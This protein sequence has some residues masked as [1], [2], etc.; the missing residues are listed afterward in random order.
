[1]RGR[2]ITTDLEQA[3]YHILFS[4]YKIRNSTATPFEI[5]CFRIM[6]MNT[7]KSRRSSKG[8]SSEIIISFS[9]S[10]LLTEYKRGVL[11]ILNEYEIMSKVCI[12]KNQ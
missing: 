11:M 5:A 3:I 12:E 7:G 2:L 6:V 10:G 4:N 8:G 1:M 9:I